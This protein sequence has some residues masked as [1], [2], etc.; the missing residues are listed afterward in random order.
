MWIECDGVCVGR[1]VYLS[2]AAE[3]IHKTRRQMYLEA[4]QCPPLFGMTYQ[5]RLL[6]TFKNIIP[7]TISRVLYRLA[8]QSEIKSVFYL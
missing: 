1:I 4:E 7:D 8:R 3:N 5:R 6:R 2:I